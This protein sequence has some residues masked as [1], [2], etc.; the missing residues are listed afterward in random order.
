[1]KN[2][3]ECAWFAKPGTPK[4]DNSTHML[5]ISALVGLI[6]AIYCCLLGLCCYY[7]L[8]LTHPAPVAQSS[9]EATALP[10]E[11]ASAPRE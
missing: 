6:V 9:Q 2:I 10:T 3:Q 8:F 5:I 1:M 11:I 4:D 7:H